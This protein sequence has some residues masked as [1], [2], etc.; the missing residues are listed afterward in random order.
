MLEIRQF[1]NAGK[2]AG[3]RLTPFFDAVF[4]ALMRVC[5]G[6][7]RIA[8]LLGGLLVI[9]GLNGCSVPDASYHN[10]NPSVPVASAA[11]Q[12]EE[13][14]NSL[15]RRPGLATAWGEELKSVVSY[16]KFNR[17]S[18][19][20]AEVETVY[21]NDEKGVKA[22]SAGLAKKESGLQ[23]SSLGLVEW[24]V[25]SGRHYVSNQ[26]VAG[27]RYVIGSK[28]VGYALVVKNLCDSELEIVFSVDGLDVID[29]KP[30]SLKKRGYILGVGKSLTVDGFR[31]NEERVAQFKFASV[32]GSYAN[33]KY[34]DARNVGVI[35]MAVYTHKGVAP[36]RWQKKDVGVRQSGSAFTEVPLRQAR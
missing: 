28:G 26:N 32:Q 27:R 9:L 13:I 8:T 2:L 33:K 25:K 4:L 7:L 10:I 34:A 15:S 16:T 11:A 18:T 23:K 35:G 12:S 6:G 3:K 5:I 24:G 1:K 36:K 19:P 21:Y 14:R 17:K 29:C 31:L 22:M 20:P 30:A